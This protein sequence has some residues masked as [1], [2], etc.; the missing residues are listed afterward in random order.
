ME[1][2]TFQ[3][4]LKERLVRERVTERNSMIIQQTKSHTNRW[5]TWSAVGV[6]LL[7]C[8]LLI[9][10]IIWIR[11]PKPVD[12]RVVLGR[13]QDT[14]NNIT[15]TDIQSF[16]LT[17]TSVT[18]YT[19]NTTHARSQIW[20]HAPNQWRIEHT[21][22]TIPYAGVDSGMQTT[23][24]DGTT[25]WRYDQSTNHL[26]I[27]H[28]EPDQFRLKND[29]LYAANNSYT[30]FQ[31][32]PT[33]YTP[34]VLGEERIAQRDTYVVRMGATTCPSN[35][36]S[37]FNGPTTIWVDKET[38]FILKTVVWDMAETHP[39]Y[40]MEVTDI[41]YN[42]NLDLTLFTYTP[43]PGST[44]TDHRISPTRIQPPT[45]KSTSPAEQPPAVTP[46]IATIRQQVDFQIFIPTN[47]SDD[48]QLQP[49]IVDNNGRGEIVEITYTSSDGSIVLKILN[50]PTGCCLDADPRKANGAITLT[51]GTRAHFL[52]G[53]PTYGGPIVWWQQDGTYIA[54]SGPQMTKEELID[55]AETMSP[56]AEFPHSHK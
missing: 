13:A 27:S 47:I 7:T 2:A 54:L 55:I 20:Y 16:I 43:Q 6:T 50:G 45:P 34:T 42:S 28:T 39:V 44:I 25:T 14:I 29:A 15:D 36:A 8:L 17:R 46:D 3:Q 4:Q 21:A 53:S 41:Q 38:F 18:T 19:M 51:D 22:S 26:Q 35:S 9:G 1:T 33:C 52:S 5:N 24:T 10:S 56:T 11:Q 37:I 31:H 12:A 30:P 40:T 23:I 48:L 49:P 32:E